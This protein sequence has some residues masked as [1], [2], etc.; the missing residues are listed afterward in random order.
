MQDT[1]INETSVVPGSP[2]AYIQVGLAEESWDGE[3]IYFRW[4]YSGE[5]L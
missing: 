5:P 1:V 4:D 2:G 3:G